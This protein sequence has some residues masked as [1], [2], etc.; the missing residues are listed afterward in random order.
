MSSIPE[1]VIEQVR[2]AADMVELIGEHV[3]LRRT[4]ADY[5]GPCPFHGG[6]H[7]NFAV[8][9]KKQMF[10]C[11]VCH[12]GGDIFTFYMKKLGMD[13]P[14]AVRDVARRVGIS[15]PERGPSGPDPREPLFSATAVAHEWYQRQ[16]R[17][18]DDARTARAYLE[19]RGYDLEALLPYG[20]GYAPPGDAFLKAMRTLGIADDVLSAAGLAVRRDDGRLRVRFFRRLLFPIHDLRGR[21]VGF[22]GRVLGEGGPKYLNSPETEI[23]HK[24]RLLYHLHTAKPAIRKAEQAVI[25]EGY[26]DVIRLVEAGVEHVVA[27]LGT[28]FT[29]E[30]AQLLR[31]LASRVILLFDSDRAGLRATFR[32]ADELL[33]AGARV[34]VATLPEGDD[35]DSLTRREGPAGV[36]RVVR[37]A[38]DVFERKLQLL[39]RKGW[40]GSLAGRR[41]ALDRLLPTLRAAADPVTRDLYVSRVREALGISRE[42]VVREIADVP[43]M[44]RPTS[45]DQPARRTSGPVPSG[46]GPLRGLL[47]VMVHHP[48]VRSTIREQIRDVESLEPPE[49]E[50]LERLG[51][52][53]EGVPAATLMEAVPPAAAALLAELLR[54]TTPPNIDAEVSG[55]LGKMEAQVLRKRRAELKRQVTVA[56][57][58]D[59]PALVERINTLSREIAHL[60]AGG[61]WRLSSTRRS[62]AG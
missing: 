57:E 45:P 19:Q 53:P 11:F 44:H 28:G 49:R 62:G 22:G 59:K 50:L 61:S 14:G 40:L 55:Y 60:D 10:Y 9:P 13:Y 56:S 33:R 54:E 34:L 25:V 5:R 23:F 38:V 8:I 12:E 43:S 31:R 41:R 39:D 21:V 1:D 30:Q 58:E 7:R 47:R 6:T 29:T 52:L 15:I 36:E 16:L 20:L 51:E 46:T 37:D 17:E 32:A 35:P 3:Q 24:G 18:S 26:F 27:P 42:S 48:Q 2:D 4:G